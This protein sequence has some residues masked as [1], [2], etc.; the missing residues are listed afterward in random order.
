MSKTVHIILY[1][2]ALVCFVIAAFAQE[3]LPRV[4]LVALGLGFWVLNPLGDLIF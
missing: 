1:L 4:S 2:L 3:R